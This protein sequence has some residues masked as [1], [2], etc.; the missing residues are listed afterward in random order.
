MRKRKGRKVEGRTEGGGGKDGRSEEYNE[1][2]RAYGGGECSICGNVCEG[3]TLA[4]V[5]IFLSYIP[6]LK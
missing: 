4:H 2:R 6:Q 1:E 5:Q 3:V